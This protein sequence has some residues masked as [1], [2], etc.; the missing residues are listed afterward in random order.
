M[1]GTRTDPPLFLTCS[2]VLFDSSVVRNFTKV[3]FGGVLAQSFAGRAVVT[4]D[5]AGE[6]ERHAAQE[7]G[8]ARL[9]ATW[10][11]GDPLQLSPDLQLEVA[12][13]VEILRPVDGHERENIGEVSTALMAERLILEGHPDTSV[14]VDDGDGARLCD[15]RGVP[16]ANTQTLIVELCVTGEL[17]EKDASRIWRGSLSNPQK[18]SGFDARLAQRRQ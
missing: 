8:L 17:T 3:G 9:L 2:P 13:I 18:W 10:P 15:Q 6:L 16:Y 1:V 11:P 4:I 7:P 5:V 14:L 12:D